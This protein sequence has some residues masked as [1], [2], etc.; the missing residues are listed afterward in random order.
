MRTHYLIFPIFQIQKFTT[1][2]SQIIFN[3]NTPKG[4]GR[5]VPPMWLTKEIGIL[6]FKAPLGNKLKG[7]TFV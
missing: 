5:G 1:K 6:D 3:V 7:K 2:E 4:Q